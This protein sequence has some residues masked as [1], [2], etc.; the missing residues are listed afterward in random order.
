MIKIYNEKEAI[1]LIREDAWDFPVDEIPYLLE[2][3]KDEA[4]VIDEDNRLWEM[5]EN[6]LEILWR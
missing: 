3:H 4:F 1:D 6:G 5:D 2:E